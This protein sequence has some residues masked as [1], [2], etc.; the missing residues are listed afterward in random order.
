MVFDRRNSAGLYFILIFL[1]NILY[2]R[3]GVTE[4]SA[5]KLH[6]HCLLCWCL[7]RHFDAPK[8]GLTE[9]ELTQEQTD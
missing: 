8:L 7:Q 2:R 4:H 9:A 6:V 5:S 3:A 1:L